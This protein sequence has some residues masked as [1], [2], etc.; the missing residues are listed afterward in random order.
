MLLNRSAMTT[1]DMTTSALE[2][3]ARL[4]FGKTEREWLL[5]FA[6]L[7]PIAPTPRLRLGISR[8]AIRRR[9]RETCR[10]DLRGHLAHPVLLRSAMIVPDAEMGSATCSWCRTKGSAGSSAS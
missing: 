4:E 7:V 10:R 6:R 5:I 2:V 8:R 3:V 1:S 9:S